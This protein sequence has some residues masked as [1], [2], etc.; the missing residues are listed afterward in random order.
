MMMAAYGGGGRTPNMVIAWLYNNDVNTNMY[1][2][3]KK[4]YL[5]KAY[6][7]NDYG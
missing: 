7:Y 4:M 3:K 1:D 6:K 5:N 2:S